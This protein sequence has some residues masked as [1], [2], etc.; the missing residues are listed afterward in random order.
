MVYPILD[1]VENLGRHLS[2]TEYTVQGNDFE[3]ILMVKM[4]P[5]HPIQYSSEF[6]AIRNH[7]V[8]MAA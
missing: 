5:R 8:V 7:C 6:W 2:C 1:T 3:L 4:E